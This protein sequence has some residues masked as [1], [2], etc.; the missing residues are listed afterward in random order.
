[1]ARNQGREIEYLHMAQNQV[2]S[3]PHSPSPDLILPSL[4]LLDLTDNGIHHIP[5]RTFEA[6]AQLKWLRLGGNSLQNLEDDS[7]NGLTRLEE[8]DLH[9]NRWVEG[10]RH[11][12]PSRQQ[13]GGGLLAPGTFMRTG[14]W[15]IVSTKDLHDNRIVAAQQRSLTELRHLKLLD[16]RGNRLEKLGAELLK[17]AGL[18]QRL[19]LSSN[20]LASVDPTAFD[21]NRWGWLHARAGATEMALLG[22]LSYS[23]I[24]SSNK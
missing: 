16:L 8:L 12:G 15:R 20:Q 22:R 14:G 6:L 5:P 17:G 7:F 13:V 21:T 4:K 2:T 11:Q 18:L 24:H 3:L 9:E 1:M 23:V 10:C 19:D